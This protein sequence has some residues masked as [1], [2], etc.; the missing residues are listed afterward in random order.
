MHIR[1]LAVGGRQ[2]GWVG[3]AFNE[4]A[5]RLPPDWRFELQSLPTARQSK[6]HDAADAMD[7]EGQSVLKALKTAERMVALDERGG[8]YDT[9]GLAERLGDWLAGG[10]DLCFVIGG[11]DG[12]SAECLAHAAE[13]WSLSKLTLPHGLVRVLLVEQLYRAWALRSGHPYHRA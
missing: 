3:D 4:Y 6:K 9:V 1:V 2:P 10:Q 13:R 7:R 5:G 8:Q 11:P 12:L